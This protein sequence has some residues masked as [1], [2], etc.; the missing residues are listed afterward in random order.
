MKN[1]RVTKTMKKPYWFLVFIIICSS[2]TTT[3]RVP[4]ETT[5]TNHMDLKYGT[6]DR[7][8]ID[9]SIPKS[10]NSKTNVI[11]YI[12][13]GA[14][15]MGDKSE[16]PKPFFEIYRDNFIVASMNYRFVSKTVNV[17]DIVN[18]VAQAI[19]FIRNFSIENGIETNKII[20][21]GLSAGGHLSLLYSYQYGQTS[22]IPVAFCVSLAGPTDFG[23]TA[24]WY[25]YR[26]EIPFYIN[27]FKLYTG[28]EQEIRREGLFPFGLNGVFLEK[29]M[30]VSPIKY[31]NVNSPPTIL[32]HDANDTFCPFSNSAKLSAVLNVLNVP[33]VFIQSWSGIGHI[34]GIGNPRNAGNYEPYIRER[35][36]LHMEE[37]IQKYC[38]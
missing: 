31:V 6:D 26:N 21:M 28:Y 23:D 9:I 33:N 1:I 11:L 38:N 3:G 37:F 36:S 8:T 20:L 18:D 12:H 5:Y 13:G 4:V 35:L 7:H 24:W 27:L 22:I 15:I 17:L 30:E 32:V 10:I 2:C 29:A 25:F 14:L 34:F 19:G 16:L